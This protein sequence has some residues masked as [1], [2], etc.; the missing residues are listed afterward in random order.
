MVLCVLPS[1][2]VASSEVKADQ[3]S[4]LCALQNKRV[5]FDNDWRNLSRQKFVMI[6]D[7]EDPR[8]AFEAG[9]CVFSRFGPVFL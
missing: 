1:P 5:K 4:F 6:L 8:E 9:R 2:L 3:L 7:A